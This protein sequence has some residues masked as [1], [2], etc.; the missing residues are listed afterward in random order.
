VRVYLPPGYAS[1]TSAIRCCTCTTARTCSTTATVFA[2]EWGVD[3]TLDALAREQG[4]EVIVVGID[5]G[6]E[7]RINE[8]K[9]WADPK[10]GAAKPTPTCASWSSGEAWVDAHYRTRRRRAT[11]ASWAVRSGG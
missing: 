8:L 5:N 7:H 9:P 2:G 11:P 3:E 1:S 4:L 6:G 10:Y